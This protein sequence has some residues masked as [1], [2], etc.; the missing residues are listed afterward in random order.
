MIIV[1]ERH[2]TSYI[3]SLRAQP[4]CFISFRYEGLRSAAS[5][6]LSTKETAEDILKYV[7][8]VVFQKYDNGGAMRA[9][10]RS[11]MKYAGQRS[12]VFLRKTMLRKSVKDVE[13]EVVHD[14]Q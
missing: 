5:G 4:A 3:Q 9:C 1:I 12:I 13:A 7:K 2:P 14:E 10:S 11:L 6:V 8:V